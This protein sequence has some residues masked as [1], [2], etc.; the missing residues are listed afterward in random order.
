MKFLLLPNQSKNW[1]YK[2]GFIHQD[3]QKYFLC[4]HCF[5]SP[6]LKYVPMQ[7]AGFSRYLGTRMFGG[8][9]R[10]VWGIKRRLCC[11]CSCET[12]VSN[13][14]LNC[15]WYPNWKRRQYIGH[16]MYSEL[17]SK[18][19][20]DLPSFDSSLIFHLLPSPVH[21]TV[22][23]FCFFPDFLVIFIVLSSNNNLR[24]V[25]K[26][27]VSDGCKLAQR[28]LGNKYFKMVLKYP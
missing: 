15:T 5:F 8:V 19:L 2:F 10:G 24:Y 18:T 11:N 16:P 27:V 14:S 4:V 17:N 25:N 12:R 23:S 6:W 28:K 21:A 26:R 13:K 9:M 22:F 7:F 3:L 20:P 1:N